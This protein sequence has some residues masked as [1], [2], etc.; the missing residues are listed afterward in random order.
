[1]G[2]HELPVE[3]LSL[4]TGGARNFHRPANASDLQVRKL[5]FW[6]VPYHSSPAFS[7]GT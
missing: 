4:Q 3:F 5:Q 6:N 2:L 7:W 1:M